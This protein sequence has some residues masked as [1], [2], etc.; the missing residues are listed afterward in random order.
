MNKDNNI[1]DVIEKTIGKTDQIGIYKTSTGSYIADTT[2]LVEG[3]FTNNP[4]LL[5]K[6]MVSRGI[7]NVQVYMILIVRQQES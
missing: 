6:Q 4:T 5:V 7:T 2:D 3:D 1:G